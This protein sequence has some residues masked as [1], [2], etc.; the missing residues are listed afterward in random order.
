MELKINLKKRPKAVF[1]WTPQW[2]AA[3]AEI[4]V[5]AGENTDLKRSPLKAWSRSVFALHA[6]LAATDF[7]LAYFYPSCP[8]TCFFTKTFSRFL[9]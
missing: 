6:T 4:Y 1:Q 9:L 7:F 2:V 3:D 5:P 8:F